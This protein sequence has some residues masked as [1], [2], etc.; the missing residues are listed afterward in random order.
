MLQRLRNAVAGVIP[1]NELDDDELDK[2][3]GFGMAS[4]GYVCERVWDATIAFV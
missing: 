2:R 3:C 1:N 4:L